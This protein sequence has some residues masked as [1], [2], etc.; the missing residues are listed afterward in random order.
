MDALI[1]AHQARLIAIDPLLPPADVP[2]GG[3]LLDRPDVYAV[4]KVDRPDIGSLD[5]TWGTLTQHNLT[6]R[7]A[8]PD[9]V[10]A[11]DAALGSFAAWIADQPDDAHGDTSAGLMWPSRDAAMTPVFLAHGLPARVNIAARPAG[12]RAPGGESDHGVEIRPVGPDDVAT[13]ADL[14]LE[15]MRWDS[16]FG[17]V[18][19]RPST[20]KHLRTEV[21]SH[22]DAPTPTQWVAVRD[23]EIVGYLA[24]EWPYDAD[25]ISDQTSAGRVAYVGAL[26][27]TPGR[28]GGGVG[29]A[30]ATYVHGLL[31]AAGIDV[32]LL[33]HATMN[34][35][36]TP[37]WN[38]FGYRPLWTAWSARPHSTLR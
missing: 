3:V 1:A 8:G 32:T 30:L 15:V 17:G 33:H 7:L 29:A 13:A 16:Q 12:R 9:P 28:R 18:T 35:L 6:V 22:L 26:S 4:V 14:Y 11:M 25:W 23:G 31:D 38:R 34:P 19:V 10:G 2:T 24:V 27:V 36:S 5:A 21:E 37:F 20:A